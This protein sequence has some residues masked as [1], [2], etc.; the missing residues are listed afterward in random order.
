MHQI[1][2]TR[3]LEIWVATNCD[4]ISV[5]GGGLSGQAGAIILGM[6]KALIA[7]DENLKEFKKTNLLPSFKVVEQKIHR[8][9]EVFVSR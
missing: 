6:S 2:V 3:P 4:V 8:K 9:I 7:H 1:I 5:K